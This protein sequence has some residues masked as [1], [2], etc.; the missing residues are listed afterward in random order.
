MNMRTPTASELHGVWL[1][2]SVQTALPDGG[3]LLP[4]GAHPNGTILYLRDGAMAVHIAGS[5]QAAGLLRAYGGRWHLIND[6][7]V[8]EVEVSFEPDLRG[9]RLQRR[10]EYDP[11]TG[12]LLYTTSE[13]QGA[14]HPVVRWRKVC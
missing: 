10:A 1:L 5:D 12:I 2:E 14:G 3:V 13:V 11:E 9:V 8:H 7:V 6:S 4:F